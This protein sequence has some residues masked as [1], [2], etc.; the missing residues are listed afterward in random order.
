MTDHTSKKV[1]GKMIGNLWE[2]SNW[3]AWLSVNFRHYDK[4]AVSIERIYITDYE[5]ENVCHMVSHILAVF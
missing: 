5:A 4:E 3:R 1:V 2:L